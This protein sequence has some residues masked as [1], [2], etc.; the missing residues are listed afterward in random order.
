MTSVPSYARR[1]IAGA[2]VGALATVL[3]AVPAQAIDPVS[4]RYIVLLEDSTPAG[5]AT[6]A[7]LVTEG[8]TQRYESIP[9]FAATLTGAEARR[10]AAD[11]QVAVVEP[12]RK[13]GIDATQAG[14]DWG[15]DRIDQH[16]DNLN[17]K[18]TPTDDG[19]SVHAYVIDT[20]IRISDCNGHGTHVAGTIG[21]S[22]YGVAK[23]AKLVA[24][25]VLDCDGE[26]WISDIIKGVDWVTRH[27]VKPAVANM[28]LG[29]DPSPALNRAVA[30]SIRSGITYAVAAGN[31]HENAANQSP[32]NLASAITVGASD[33]NDQRAYF[34]NYGKLVDIFAPGE[35]ITSAWNSSNTATAVE[36]GTSMASPHVAGAAALILDAH[37]KWSPAAV[38]AYLVA[39]STKGA[40]T[41]IGS[42]SPNRLLY[43]VRPPARPVIRTA[44]LRTGKVGHGYRMQLALSA[45]RRGTWRIVGGRLPSGLRLSSTGLLTGTPRGTVVRKV[46]VRFTDYVPH[47]VARTLIVRVVR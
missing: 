26:G 39:H 16:S 6:A 37:P 25:R 19:S 5:I 18:F 30:A 34:S 32:A 44:T 41:S 10:L 40:L 35:E 23:K 42:G 4:G 31:E 12:D 24:V 3:A 17:D 38:R 20:G 28:S 22:T 47:S 2:T 27:A 36:S 1:L 11:P 15:L 45:G 14:A 43:T 13:I 29:G 21:G 46:T 33:W 9:G 8:V 7:G